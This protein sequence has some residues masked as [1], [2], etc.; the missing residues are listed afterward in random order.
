[1]LQLR[2]HPDCS[3]PFVMGRILNEFQQTYKLAMYK[4]LA[5]TIGVFVALFSLV[6]VLVLLGTQFKACL[7]DHSDLKL[8]VVLCRS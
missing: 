6:S 2:C 5:W 8:L 3:V 1:M 4:R 7:V